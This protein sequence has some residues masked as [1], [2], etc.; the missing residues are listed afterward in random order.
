MNIYVARHGETDWNKKNIL[1]GST[2]K[3][4]N[5]TGKKQ[6]I[7]LSKKLQHIKFDYIISSDLKRALETANI[8]KKDASIIK[9][10]KL[11]ERNY[12]LLEGTSPKNIR[13]FWNVSTNLDES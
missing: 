7:E 8:V 13:D 4:L 1:L 9:N 6:A 2:D 10:S 12:G 5:E 11:R 3:D